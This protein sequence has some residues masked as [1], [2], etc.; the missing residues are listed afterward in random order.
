VAGGLAFVTDHLGIVELSQVCA[1]MRSRNLELFEQLGS[2]VATTSDG[3]LQ[4]LFAEACHRHASHAELWERRAPTI[5]VAP[6]SAPPHRAPEITGDARRR[7]HYRQAL[8]GLRDELGSLGLRVES[9]CDPSSRR[10]IDLVAR[11]VD[12]L[13]ARLDGLADG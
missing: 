13:T 11:D 2:W 9:T 7:D 3:A 4:R 12:D 5:P 10:T 6:R 8:T 1:D